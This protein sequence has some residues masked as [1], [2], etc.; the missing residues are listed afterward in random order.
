MNRL[1]FNRL[2][3]VLLEL[4]ENTVV[5]EDCSD[6]EYVDELRAEAVEIVNDIEKDYMIQQRKLIDP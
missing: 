4:S 3:Q 5:T 1:V 6:P 2:R